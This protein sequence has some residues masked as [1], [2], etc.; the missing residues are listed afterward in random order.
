MKELGAFLNTA[1]RAARAAADIQLEGLGRE[2]AVGTKSSP[3][4][5]VTEIDSAAEARIREIL[6]GEHPDHAILGEEGGASG[7]GRH[8]WLVDPLDGTVNYAHG[9]PFFCVSVALEI[10]GQ[11]VV[12][13]V[14]DPVR[15]ETFVATRDGGA[16][17]NGRPLR[18]SRTA[19][20]GGRALLATGFPYDAALAARLVKVFARFLELGIPVRRP[21]AAA[22]DL[23]YVA[24]GRLDGFWEHKLQP[25]DCAAGNLIIEEA[26]GKVT[27]DVGAAYSHENHRVVA[28]NGLIHD[29]ILKVLREA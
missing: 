13:V 5:L 8:R 2:I 11:A 29:A 23:C 27:D 25:W 4:D 9:F 3:A 26:G 20:L 1:L 19:E 14:L 12:G 24:C 21:G 28:S 6:L 22:L 18:V 7:G 17:L 10:D 15:D 16:T